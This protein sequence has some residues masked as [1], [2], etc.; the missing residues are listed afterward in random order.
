MAREFKKEEA[1]LPEKLTKIL[2]EFFDAMDD[3]KNGEVS[4]DEAVKFWGKNFAKVNAS[5]MFNEVDE[6]GNKTI[7][8]EEFFAFWKNVV[9]SGVCHT[10]PLLLRPP[11]MGAARGR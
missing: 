7:T 9:A 3:D 5:A 2:R 11:S 8:W 10:S 4:K 1:E 6:D